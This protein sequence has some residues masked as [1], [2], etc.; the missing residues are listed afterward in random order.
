MQDLTLV[1]LNYFQ[2]LLQDIDQKGVHMDK[3]LRKSGLNQFNLTNSD[4]FVPE[5]CYRKLLIGLNDE[6]V[7]SFVDHFRQA[8]S[9]QNLQNVGELLLS[10]P[11]VLS[12][13]NAARVYSPH[14]FQSQ[15]VGLSVVGAISYLYLEFEGLETRA[16]KHMYDIEVGFILDHF[17]LACGTSWDPLELRLPAGLEP[18]LEILLNRPDRVRVSS[19]W[20][21]IEVVFPSSDLSTRFEST[22]DADGDSYYSPQSVKGKI[23]ALLDGH[24]VG[25][26]PS[27]QQVAEYFYFSDSTLRRVLQQ[28]E[29]TFETIVGEWRFKSALKKLSTNTSTL[30]I[31]QSLGY[32]NPQNFVR[33][34]NRW[35]G[36]SPQR[37]REQ[38]SD[39]H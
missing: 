37:Y 3:I 20:D 7:D 24:Q 39:I 26:L 14:F 16:H 4:N 18:D 11:D 34:F 19:G 36:T 28:E 38:L 21:R 35:S 13:I 30:E 8:L 6:G 33:A 2:F 29:T 5:S 17:R 23:E 25:A 12:A 27:M 15:R 1:Q 31:S 22:T 9:V 32:T 10:A